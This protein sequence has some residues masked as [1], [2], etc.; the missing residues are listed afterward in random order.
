VAQ[1]LKLSWSDRVC[2]VAAPARRCRG[3]QALAG[4]QVLRQDWPGKDNFP[5]SHARV[6]NLSPWVAWFISVASSHL[7]QLMLH[8]IRVAW[9]EIWDNRIGE[10]Y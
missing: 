1:S 6:G 8:G 7:Q 3:V 9:F 5:A 4:K 2:R 10:L